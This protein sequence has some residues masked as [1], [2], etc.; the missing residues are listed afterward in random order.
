[1]DQPGQA[2]RD[3]NDFG[4]GVYPRL[5]GTLVLCGEDPASAAAR[6]QKTVW[7]N[8]QGGLAG[9]R[10]AG[11][12]VVQEVLETA[13]PPK[14]AREPSDPVEAAV[15]KLPWRNRLATVSHLALGVDTP[16]AETHRLAGY[17]SLYP[18]SDE[19][20]AR[21]SAAVDA[22]APAPDPDLIRRLGRH[23]RN[24]RIRIGI[25]AGLVVVALVVLVILLAGRAAG[26]QGGAS[27]QPVSHSATRPSG[28]HT[29]P[30]RVASS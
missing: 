4:M 21:I 5:V 3:F 10:E 22:R 28:I 1:V 12:L 30:G 15:A 9:G 11:T 25:L 6:V 27:T 23:A 19:L 26:H 13:R 7:R 2:G 17:L 24:R 8:V 20:V 18:G 14:P 16:G 29:I